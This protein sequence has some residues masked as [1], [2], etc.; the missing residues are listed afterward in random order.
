M[1][2]TNVK[3]CKVNIVHFFALSIQHMI[4]MSHGKLNSTNEILIV[5][6]HRSE[7]KSSFQWILRAESIQQSM[8][9]NTS[10]SPINGR[11]E[12]N[13]MVETFNPKSW[14]NVSS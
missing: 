3:F 10:F 5:F 8:I 13:V 6:A 1:T 4:L 7:K 9:S 14:L 11:D 2:Q 12:L